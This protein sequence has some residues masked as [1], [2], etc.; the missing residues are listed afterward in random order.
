MIQTGFKI[1]GIGLFFKDYLSFIILIPAFIGGIW[2]LIELMSISQPYISF[3]S[4]SQ[5]VPDGILILIFLLLALAS[6]M[7]PL[8][9]DSILPKKN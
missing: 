1:N 3:F 2:Q 8:F 4:I 7:F 5:I 9:L 6:I